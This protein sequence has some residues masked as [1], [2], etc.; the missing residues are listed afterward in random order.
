MK[1][2]ILTFLA[3][4]PLFFVSCA[5]SSLRIPG[6][7][8]IILKNLATEY[9]TIAD[10][11][12]EIKNYTKAAQYYKLAMRNED[13]YLA[14][15]YKLARSYALAKDWEN[16]DKTYREL[17]ELDSENT[18]LK[19]SLAYI[20]VMRGEL[21]DGILMYK[22]LTEE[23]PYDEN[24]LESY[25]SLL[26]NVGRGEDAEESFFVLKEKFPDNKQ[27]STFSQ[28]LSE[29][30]DNFDPDKKKEQTAEVESDKAPLGKSPDKKS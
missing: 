21:D 8:R 29:I 2:N 14:A 24:L 13:L 5:S 22:K 26:I 4:F 18:V 27:I 19:T 10:G 7:S 9:Y 25:V 6:E 17:L 12:L 15:F 16:A 1:K 23:N 28:S 3:F 11:Y 20:T 30:V